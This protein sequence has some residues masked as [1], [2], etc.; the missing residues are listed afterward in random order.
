MENMVNLFIT[1]L[2]V[3]WLIGFL[4]FDAGGLIHMLLVVAVIVL[5]LKFIA[6]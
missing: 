4:A 2:V 6:G 3:G 5:L 1:I